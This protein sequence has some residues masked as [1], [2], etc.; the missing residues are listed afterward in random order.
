[1]TY[2]T[3]LVDVT[4]GVATV[5]LNRPEV[6]N[7]LSATLLRELEETLAT[8]EANPAARVIVLAGGDKAFCAGADLKGVGIVGPRSRLARPSAVSRASS[9]IWRA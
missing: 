5:T 3:L 4:N 2:E 9:K 6:R 1:V 7:A 8:L